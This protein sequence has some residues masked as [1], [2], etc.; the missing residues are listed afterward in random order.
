MIVFDHAALEGG[1]REAALL[2]EDATEASL[3]EALEAVA[4]GSSL[5][6]QL[7]QAGL[8]CA[9]RFSWRKTAEETAAALLACAGQSPKRQ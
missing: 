6:M 4:E 7:R 9:G 2:V 5:R 1:L 8:D 3:S